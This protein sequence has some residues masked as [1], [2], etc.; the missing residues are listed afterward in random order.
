[1]STAESLRAEIEAERMG[2]RG[3]PAAGL[4]ELIRQGRVA[5]AIDELLFFTPPKEFRSRGRRA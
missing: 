2:R 5:Q 1:M 3:L 4:L